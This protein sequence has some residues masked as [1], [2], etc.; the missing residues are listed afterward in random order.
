MFDIKAG[1]RKTL[2]RMANDQMAFSEAVG[3][4]SVL[5]V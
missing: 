3:S 2:V 1:I 4:V 5:F